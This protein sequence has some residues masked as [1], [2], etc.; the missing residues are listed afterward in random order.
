MERLL[1][2]AKNKDKVLSAL[3]NINA[4]V[5]YPYQFKDGILID[6]KNDKEFGIG[7]L[8]NF[9][10][11]SNIN[12]ANLI[13]FFVDCNLNKANLHEIIKI[14][15]ESNAKKYIV[16]PE[17]KYDKIKDSF[18]GLNARTETDKCEGDDYSIKTYETDI[19]NAIE[20]SKNT[21]NKSS[22]RYIIV[23]I[24]SVLV[25]IYFISSKNKT[26]KPKKLMETNLTSEKNKNKEV[27]KEKEQ[28]ESKNYSYQEEL[29]SI[30]NEINK[31]I[32]NKDI[33]LLKDLYKLTLKNQSLKE[34]Y[35]KK[36][37]S[38]EGIPN[39]I[40]KNCGFLP[41][42]EEKEKETITL[43]S[44]IEQAYQSMSFLEF[45]DFVKK[46]LLKKCNELSKDDKEKIKTMLTK[47]QK[48]YAK[49][50]VFDVPT[51]KEA[52]ENDIKLYTNAFFGKLKVDR[53]FQWD[54]TAL[55]AP[56]FNKRTFKYVKLFNSYLGLNFK[57]VG[58]GIENETFKNLSN[59]TKLTFLIKDNKKYELELS[60]TKKDNKI[61]ISKPKNA[62]G[63]IEDGIDKKRILA[64]KSYFHLKNKIQVSLLLQKSESDKP[65]KS[66]IKDLD[67]KKE[68]KKAIIDFF[69]DPNNVKSF[70]NK[71]AN[72]YIPLT[73]EYY[74][75][76]SPF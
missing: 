41:K 53:C 63:I 64:I 75:T 16:I 58:I 19:V 11:K 6:V 28:N 48:E 72:F 69:K 42:K 43:L 23:I 60:Y 56:P 9:E 33:V 26:S 37:K 36:I 27:K 70:E 34:F 68:Y 24:G 13:I 25:T 39:E 45:V 8:S 55:K 71:S 59:D 61:V 20:N 15:K 35:C 5:N 1:I 76:L 32:A 3:K 44:K 7:I 62:T 50:L 22:L 47:K 65:F 73:N 49:N 46:V 67:L 40:K 14:L 4:N 66:Y 52:L 12:D 29:K 31:A 2:I 51:T 18:E 57:K 21:E 54:K 30:K 17:E 38:L 74:L 10:I